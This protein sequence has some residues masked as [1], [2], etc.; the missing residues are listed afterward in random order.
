M[1]TV[2]MGSIRARKDRPGMY[3]ATYYVSGQRR[4]VLAE[5]REDVSTAVADLIKDP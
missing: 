3:E 4:R 2:K 1:A 5:S